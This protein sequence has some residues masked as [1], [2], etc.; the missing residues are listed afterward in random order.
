MYMII[1]KDKIAA[2]MLAVGPYIDQA[3]YM[4]TLE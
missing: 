1:T 3:P 4:I 2:T